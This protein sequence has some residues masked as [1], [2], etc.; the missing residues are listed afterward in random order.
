MDQ[1]MDKATAFNL[2]L[3]ENGVQ[4]LPTM[5][6]NH[7]HIPNPTSNASKF[8]IFLQRTWERFI[9][10]FHHHLLNLIL[11][12]IYPT[13]DVEIKGGLDLSKLLRTM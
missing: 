5:T 4:P 8:Q 9:L 6:L 7:I 2:F 11:I 1:Q 12:I 3:A 10:C 13:L